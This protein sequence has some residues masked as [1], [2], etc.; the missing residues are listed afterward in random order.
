MKHTWKVTLVV[1]ALFLLTQLV[2][3]AVIK[4]FTVGWQVHD[5]IVDEKTGQ[6]VEIAKN[7]S[8]QIPYGFEPPQ[9]EPKV[10]LIT[11]IISIIVATLI[12]LLLGR[13]KANLII[14][15]WFAFVVLIT[16]AITISVITPDYVAIVIAALLTY[17]KIFR[18]D[19]VVHN[20]T[21]VLI[22]P[23]LASIF[24]PILSIGV[25]VLLLIFLSFYDFYAVIKSKHMIELAK[26]QMK[27]LKIF[28]GFFLPY[29]RPEDWKKVK[30]AR[31][32]AKLAKSSRK[33]KKVKEMKVK[34]NVAILGGGDVAFP[35]IFAGVVLKTFNSYWYGAII[36]VFSTAALLFLLATAKKG[37]FYPAMTFTTAGALLGYGLV[38]LLHSLG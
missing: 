32:Q 30:E 38:W 5:T 2:G 19:L 22:Y 21:E 18:R 6:S 25:T 28:T 29:L 36:A 26:Y 23:G 31:R 16:S 37:K 12:I 1:L 24:V 20:I 27:E 8:Q 4:T 9:V 7:L 11:I 33:G 10:S 3:L 34:V 13:I 17:F 15:L 14:K 35:L